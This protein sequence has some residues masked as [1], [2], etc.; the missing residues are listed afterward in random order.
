MD[1]VRY[2]SR[3]LNLMNA[4]LLGC[5]IM[6][7]VF[8]VLP[9]FHLKIGHVLPRGQSATDVRDVLP[10]AQAASPLVPDYATIGENNLFHPERRVPPEKKVRQPLPRPDLA[11]YGTVIADG[12]SLAFIEDKKSPKT[13]AGRGK[14][15]SVVRKGDVLSG[16]VL[17]E[18]L[19]DRILLSSGE[20]SMTVYLLEAGKLREGDGHQA[21][22][23]PAG[24][25]AGPTPAAA[26]ASGPPANTTVRA[27]PQRVTGSPAPGLVSKETRRG[28]VYPN[29]GQ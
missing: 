22:T 28:R 19:A 8:V 4:I 16:F 24:G 18:I 20:E 3:S 15:Q 17:K 27:Y 23:P 5:L 2:V 7:A 13:S 14:R 6:I 9:L 25:A 1:A 11:L 12:S 10:P 29:A 26:S 21:K